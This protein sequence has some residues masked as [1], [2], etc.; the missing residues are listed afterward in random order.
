MI[1]ISSQILFYLEVLIYL[2]ATLMHLTKK[3]R[4]I[5]FLYLFQSLITTVLLVIFSIE[6][7]SESLVF[8]IFLTFLVKVILAPLF[9]MKL[10]K[11]HQ[12]QIA[13]STYLNIPM[14]LLVLTILTAVTH[15]HFLE[16]LTSLSPGEEKLLLLSV[17]TILISLFL[18]INRK[19]ALSQMIGI[20]SLENAI[21]SFASFARLEHNPGLQIG[22]I[23]DLLVWTIIATVFVS[24]I[25][26]KFGT[27]NI[28]SIKK[29]LEE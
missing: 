25:F 11:R 18:I 26:R 24:M 2:S 23:F 7:F 22:I 15:Y 17:A 12:L 4:S 1:E 6:K 13:V 14:T 8:V 5:I 27:L 20:L 9:F 29:T 19:G 21:V 10:V 28:T 3:N 16:P